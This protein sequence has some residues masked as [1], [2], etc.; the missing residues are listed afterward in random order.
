MSEEFLP[1]NIRQKAN[2]S[3]GGEYVWQIGD[4]ETVILAAKGARLASLGGQAQFILPEG[5]CEMYWVKY[6]SESRKSNE[7]WEAYVHRS[8]DEVLEK[9]RSMVTKIDFMKEA[10]E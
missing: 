8:A 3:P 6:D 10:S 2:V 7:S 9:F 1:V 5:T 4:F